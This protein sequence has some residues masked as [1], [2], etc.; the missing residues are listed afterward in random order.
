MKKT[1]GLIASVAIAGN[2]T[3]QID[4]RNDWEKMALS[5][6]IKLIKESVD[7]VLKN[8][9]T[10]NDMGYLTNNGQQYVF[11]SKGRITMYFSSEN[12][13][14]I[15]EYNSKGLITEYTRKNGDEMY[16]ETYVYDASGKMSSCNTS[17]STINFTYDNAGN[18]THTNDGFGKL[19]AE[20]V[21][22]SNSRL[23]M[24][25]KNGEVINYTYDSK[26]RKTNVT[27][28][29]NNQKTTETYSYNAEGAINKY[30][31]TIAE[32][33]SQTTETHNYTVDKN[34]NWTKDDIT[35][36]KNGSKSTVSITR[37]IEYFPPARR[38]YLLK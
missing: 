6:D 18:L 11:D 1:I 17:N 25:R 33:G 21:Y 37:E 29:K 38:L 30:T 14:G 2:L 4:L 23:S 27:T 36:D 8:T 9:Y 20:Y 34:G 28:E 3:A 19:L 12:G 15:Y 26:G 10:F 32:N 22:D 31:V 16:R 24:E 7:G 5:P 35:I 13:K